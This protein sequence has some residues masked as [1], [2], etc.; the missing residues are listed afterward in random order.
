MVAVSASEA[1]VAPLLTEGVS[2][3]AVNGPDSV[4]LSG[5]QAAVAAVADRLAGRGRRVHRLAVSHAFHSPLMEPMI[6]DFSAVVAEVSAGEPRMGLVS[7]LTGQLAGPGYGSAAYWV[8]HV[9]QPV[10]FVDGV[11]LAE[12]LG[13]GVFV[14]V[15]P[16]AAL[17]AAVEQ[18]L[19]TEQAISVVTMAKD[20]P[21]IDSLLIAAGQLFATGVSVDWAAALCRLGC[22][23]GGVADVCLSTTQVLAAD[24]VGGL[25]GC[26]QSGV[27]GGRACVVGRSG[28]AA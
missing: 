5:E 20:R 28:G 22:P 10:R 27:G 3:A 6:E 24:R 26:G 11:Q 2:I 12:S 1:E 13:A 7:N 9:R 18:S 4:V 21:E 15:G 14:E 16:G 25:Q 8:E 23:T 17:T 19:T